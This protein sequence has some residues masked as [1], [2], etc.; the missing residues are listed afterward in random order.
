VVISTGSP[1]PGRGFCVVCGRLVEVEPSR[2]GGDAA[3]P[4]CGSLVWLRSAHDSP[5]LEVGSCAQLS[6]AGVLGPHGRVEAVD[7]SA[8]RVLVG[9]YGGFQDISVE[10]SAFHFVVAH[11]SM[12]ERP[13]ETRPCT[14]CRSPAQFNPWGPPDSQVCTRCG[15]SPLPHIRQGLV[16][17]SIGQ[18]VRLNAGVFSGAEGRVEGVNCIDGRVRLVLSGFVDAVVRVTARPADVVAID[19]SA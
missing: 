16:R 18:V 10:A 8:N 1:E 15:E 14:R 2:P 4:Y 6:F 11:G 17:Y 7:D 12:R 9:F 19:G 3:C 5:I 13:S